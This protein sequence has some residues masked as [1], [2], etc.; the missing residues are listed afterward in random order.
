MTMGEHIVIKYRGYFIRR[1]YELKSDWW[2]EKDAQWLFGASSLAEA[3]RKVDRFHNG[4]E[5]P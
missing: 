1:H 4:R 3:K 2:V 5:N